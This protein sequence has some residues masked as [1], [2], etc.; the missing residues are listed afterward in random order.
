MT[1]AIRVILVDDHVMLRQGL[2]TLLE[3]EAN[4]VVV[5]EAGDGLEAVRTARET[6]ADVVLMD[7][8]M[9][10][11][12][13]I[14]AM[15]RILYAQPEVRVV[16][17]SMHADARYVREALAAGASGYVL[18]QSAFDEVADA[19]RAAAAGTVYLSPAAA[20]VVA[21]HFRNP[22]AGADEMLGRLTP[23]EREVLQLLAEGYSA[24]EIASKLYLS[25]KTVETHRRNIMEKLGVHSLAGLTKCALQ[26]GL[27][28]L[29]Q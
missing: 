14:E 29:D 24:R 26:A 16:I 21:A 9:P 7:V 15:R 4:I 11:L 2:R 8:A 22:A 13:G 5:G 19:V 17:L 6:E 27:I 28:V 23:R 20:A 18:K 12:N 1:D 25:V 3:Q 10:E